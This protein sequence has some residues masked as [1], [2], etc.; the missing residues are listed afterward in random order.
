MCSFALVIRFSAAVVL[1][2]LVFPRAL[3]RLDAAAWRCGFWTSVPFA[4]GFLLQLVGLT[5][6]EVSP[7]ES[8]F[9]TALYVVATPA[10]VAAM[11]RRLPGRGVL[12]G[13]PLALIGAA[14]VSGPPRAGLSVGA[15]LTI[16]SAI[17]FGLHIVVT[18]RLTRRCDPLAM[19][20][21]MIAFTLGWMV[22]ALVVAPGGPA[23]ARADAVMRAL[24]DPTFSLT[25][26]GCALLA[27]VVTLAILNRYQKE[28]SPSRAALLYTSEPIF[29]ALISVGAGREAPTG[30][31]IF[32]GLMIL[33]ANL[34]A[35]RLP[36]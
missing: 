4:L 1:L 34:V 8:A 6:D 30:W 7:S 19:T 25:I 31:L 9:L 36:I 10:T 21:T 22:L 11:E 29:A 27:T 15:W 17:V 32:G 20:F 33:A 26:V 14:F 24:A 2:P 23:L 5:A 18:D 28:L 16:A 3:T 12:L 13:V 35:E